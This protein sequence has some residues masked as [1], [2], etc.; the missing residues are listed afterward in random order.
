MLGNIHTRARKTHSHASHNDTGNY[1]RIK[2]MNAGSG[3][4][5]MR[6]F[7]LNVPKGEI[8]GITGQSGQG[9]MLLGKAVMGVNPLEGE[10]H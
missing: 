1:F 3:G 10:I 5:Y 2:N 4:E 8:I 7:S 6:D 9:Q